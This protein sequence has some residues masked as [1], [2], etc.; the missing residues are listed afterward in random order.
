[1]RKIEKIGHPIFLLSIVLLIVN[2]WYL[3]MEF[4]NTLT[5]KLSDF[6]GL[7]AFS[8][9]LGLIF[10]KH[11]KAVHFL[12]AILFITWNSQIV[13]PLIDY[14][15]GYGVPIGRTIDPTDNIALI[16]IIASFKCLTHNY[17]FKLRPISQ[18]S[19]LIIAC[20][21][22]IA[23][24]MP[25]KKRQ[26]FVDINKEYHFEFSKRQL[27]S[28]L[29]MMQIDEIR[30]LDDGQGIIDFDPET[31][32]FHYTNRNDT[33]AILLDYKT[34]ADS[35]TI[36]LKTSY[37]EILIFGDETKSSLKLISVSKIVPLLSDNKYRN[38]AVKHFEK[39]V[40]NKIKD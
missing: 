10:S 27:I 18:Y 9:L 7:F 5:G 25:P 33:L 1:M 6:S 3:K 17:R 39:R 26:K 32:I 38:K 14:F 8:F 37:A 40:I 29:N 13:Q 16:S 34:I 12:V 36:P 35:D 30:K 23:T 22:F 31:N 4:H 20:L 19:I 15:N 21:A 11:K 28:K 2:D 24:S